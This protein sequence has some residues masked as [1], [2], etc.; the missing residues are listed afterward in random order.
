MILMRLGQRILDLRKKQGYTQEKL[1]ELSDIS[2]TYLAQLERGEK[3]PTII[4]IMKIA[5]GLDVDGATL[6]ENI[7]L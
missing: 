3:A 1:A 6:I 7:K 2:S 5:H 4:V